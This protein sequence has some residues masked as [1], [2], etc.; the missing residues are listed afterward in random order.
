MSLSDV[1]GAL[2]KRWWLIVIVPAIVFPLLVLRARAQP[3]QT[4][5]NAVVLIPGDTEIPGNSERPELMVLDDLP[6]LVAS[7]VFAEA[8]A[9]NLA[10]RGVEPDLAN[11]INSIQGAL[12]ADRYSRVLTVIVTRANSDEAL[13]L[14]ES[15]AAV[16]P[17]QVN[18][19]LVA[20][21]SAPA[22]VQIIDPPGD[23]TRSRPNQ[24]LIIAAITL[25]A[26]GVGGGIALLAEQAAIGGGAKSG[27]NR[28]RMGERA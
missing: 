15:A 1:L 17:D 14:A 2:R 4:T 26:A 24:S 27:G 6:T 23:P 25:I 3:Y 5:L 21:Q 20:D 19:Y 12:S 10:A 22:T 28:D 7:R 16:L 13:A 9:E 11:D 18:R 8:I